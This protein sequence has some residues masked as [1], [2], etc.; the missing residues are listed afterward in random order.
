MKLLRISRI[1]LVFCCVALV[2]ARAV[3][4]NEVS[5]GHTISRSRRRHVLNSNS[6]SHV[7]ATRRKH[8]TARLYQIT[9]VSQLRREGSW[10]GR[11][12]I[13]NF[14]A[15]AAQSFNPSLTRWGVK[16][17]EKILNGEELYRL[18]TPIFLHGGLGHLFTNAF[19]LDAVGPDLER[20]FGPGRFLSTYFASGIAGNYLSAMKSP[21]PSLGASGA[22][23]GIVGAYFT[24]LSMNSNAFGPRA[25]ARMDGLAQTVFINAIMGLANPMID[26]WGHAG[27]FLGGVSMAVLFG[28]R[29]NLVQFDDG[30]H[31]LVDKPLLRAPHYIERIPNQ[32]TSTFSKVKERIQGSK[33][34]PDMLDRPWRTHG[35]KRN[36][37]LRD[38][39]KNQSIKPVF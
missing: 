1:F 6:L 16:L 3:I 12:I 29:L 24:F 28:P 23:F 4:P 32:I 2:S 14:L 26:N 7:V 11:L 13:I 21:N 35:R 37:A 36:R 30:S 10:A 20:Y 34:M 39:P 8:S 25:E 5:T 31:H 38:F 17:S 15:F 9:T 33:Y 19:S 27:G 22:V 18:F